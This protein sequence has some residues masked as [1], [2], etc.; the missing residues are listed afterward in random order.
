M[1]CIISCT[2]S[3]IVLDEFYNESPMGY[4]HVVKIQNNI[5]QIM[6]KIICVTYN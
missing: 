1:H 4:M 2:D 3:S 5:K 6:K